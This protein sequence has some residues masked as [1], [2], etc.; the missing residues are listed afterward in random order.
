MLALRLLN[1]H[2]CSDVLCIVWA[3]PIVMD[4][5]G[6]ARAAPAADLEP[7]VTNFTP[8]EPSP[9][10]S[11]AV[12]AAAAKQE[13]MPGERPQPP[14]A[15]K[16]MIWLTTRGRQSAQIILWY[17]FPSCHPPDPEEGRQEGLRSP[18]SFCTRG[19]RPSGR[20]PC[21]NFQRCRYTTNLTTCRH[22]VAATAVHMPPGPCRGA[23][24]YS[25]L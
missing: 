15:G 20:R 2:A 19:A 6:G 11:D 25:K 24:D 12:A 7:V 5:T 4:S 14:S 8:K 21:S 13:P 22:R 10:F 23:G 3:L 9:G 18:S 16:L 1:R 17:C